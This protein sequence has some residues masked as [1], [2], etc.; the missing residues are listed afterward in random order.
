MKILLVGHSRCG[1]DTVGEMLE[2]ITSLKYG[3]TASKYL[4]P[5]VCERTGWS[6]EEAYEHRHEYRKLWYDIGNEVR[7]KDP[8]VLLRACTEAGDIA[9]GIRDKEELYHACEKG[10]VTHIVWI[11]APVD[12][13]PTLMFTWGQVIQAC[14]QHDVSAHF[15]SNTGTLEDLFDEVQELA[16]YLHEVYGGVMDE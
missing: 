5:Y 16:L 6:Y 14:E 13:D 7:S 4:C 10:L 2:D 11:E 1:K 3:G 12:P 8:G 15:L 9:A